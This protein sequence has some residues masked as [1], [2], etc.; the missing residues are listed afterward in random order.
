MPKTQG[1]PPKP[2]ALE[3]DPLMPSATYCQ[4]C[5]GWRHRACSPTCS[6]DF[7]DLDEPTRHRGDRN[8][9]HTPSYLDEL[10]D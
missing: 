7:D 4:P 8:R 3:G 10:D 5:K 2:P 6:I 1:T 9:T